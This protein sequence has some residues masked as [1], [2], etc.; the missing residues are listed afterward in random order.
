MPRLQG[1]PLGQT[2][3]G[4]QVLRR[5]LQVLQVVN[6]QP[7]LCTAQIATACG[8]ARTTTQRILNTLH[9]DG[10]LRRDPATRTYV[11]SQRVLSLSGGFD[12]TALVTERAADALSQRA[13]RI[14]WPMHFATR[15]GRAMVVRASTDQSSPLAVHKLLPGI[16]I[17]LLQCSA[18]LAWLAA[19]PQSQRTPVLEDALREPGEVAWDRPRL[20]EALHYCESRGH[21]VFRRPQRISAMIG[22]S[23]PVQLGQFGTAALSVRFAEKAVS[24][25]EAEERF[26]PEL[27]AAAAQVREV[28]ALA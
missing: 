10:F 21:A 28:A 3:D 16:R 23:V 14:L 20:E 7:G 26:V 1:T 6:A 4:V 5:G 13:G 15:D 17:P 27:L 22:L 8:L 19:Q 24:L 2:P 11:P 18:G 25:R 9:N 12:R